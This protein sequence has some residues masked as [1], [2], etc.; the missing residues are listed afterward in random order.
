MCIIPRSKAGLIR[1]QVMRVDWESGESVSHQFWGPIELKITAGISYY[2]WNFFLFILMFSKI[3]TN[4]FTLEYRTWG[5]TVVCDGRLPTVYRRHC[6]YFIPARA[7]LNGCWYCQNQKHGSYQRGW[8]RPIGL[9]RR[10]DQTR[11]RGAANQRSDDVRLTQSSD[12]VRSRSRTWLPTRTH[13]Y[14]SVRRAVACYSST[15]LSKVRNSLVCL[16][17]HDVCGRPADGRRPRGPW[18]LWKFLFCRIMAAQ[19]VKQWKM[20]TDYDIN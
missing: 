8:P 9:A 3:F 11:R 10:A 13:G 7:S 12:Q 14:R 15:S 4:I 20:R 1:I 5:V 16:Y 17:K 19:T 6:S 2:V 18:Q